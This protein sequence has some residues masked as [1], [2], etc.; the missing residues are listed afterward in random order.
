MGVA[1]IQITL[2]HRILANVQ[3][4]N[5]MIFAVLD[6]SYMATAYFFDQEGFLTLIN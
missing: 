4:G 3:Y 1:G 5:K 6:V 2:D